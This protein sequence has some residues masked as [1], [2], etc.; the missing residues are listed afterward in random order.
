M[1][2]QPRFITAADF[3]GDARPDLVAEG[4]ADMSILFRGRGD[5]TFGQG[6]LWGTGVYQMTPVGLNEDAAA[7][8]LTLSQEPGYVNATLSDGRR[9]FEAPRAFPTTGQGEVALGD[10][11][12][13]GRL[14]VLIEATRFRGDV[15]QAVVTTHLNLGGGEFGR[16]IVS[17]ATEVESFSG[18][19]HIELAD[20]D[21]DGRLD[22]A[23]G[24]SH[25]FV[26]D[27]QV[28]TMRG[29]G[30]GRFAPAVFDSPGDDDVDVQSFALADVTG[31]GELDYIS[32]TLSKLSVLPGN[33]DG[34]FGTPILSGLA[35]PDQSFTLV[36]DF[37]GDGVSDVLAVRV[38]G[39]DDFS[40]S[41][42]NYHRGNGDGTFVLALTVEIDTNVGGAGVGDFD[43]DGRPDV[44]VV[45]KAGT[46]GG[47]GG[48][49]TVANGA[50]GEV[51]YPG[52][53][54]VGLE[55]ADYNLDGAPDIATADLYVSLNDGG[56]GFGQVEALVAPAEI[57][58]AGDLTGDGKP[59]IVTNVDAFPYR[60]AL[61]VN[62]T[63]A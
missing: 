63:P 34:T 39:D 45:G 30:D 11:N 4:D 37:D 61:F 47:R 15:T 10:V 50:S 13:D 53:G 62:A 24:M 42:L 48:L 9:G 26:N 59:D 43:G 33:G 32:H 57:L 54:T 56:G 22:L 2:T 55:V 21:D 60:F 38:T 5:G 7:D 52:R 25:L 23:G 20:L 19:S 6:S 51:H 18:I 14:D 17:V 8:L 44:A 36:L 3:T 16:G 58:A 46:N 27:L 40:A 28:F 41:D 31:D 35:G 29:R 49:F 1:A 12:G